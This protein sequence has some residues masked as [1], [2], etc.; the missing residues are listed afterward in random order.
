MYSMTGFGRCELELDGRKISLELKSVNHRYLDI[1]VRLPRSISYIEEV[2]KGA[3]KE[4]LNRG[5]VDVY[6]YYQNLRDD[7]KEVTVDEALLKSYHDVLQKIHAETGAANDISATSLARMPDVLSVQNV[8]EDEE[9]VIE[10]TKT[11]VHKALDGLIAMR[12]REGIKMAED[13]MEKA[14]AME[15]LV[16]VVSE[17]SPLVVTEYRDKLRARIADLMKD[18]TATLDENKLANEV[19]FFAD[20]CS[21][22]EEITRLNC[23]LE[24]LEQILKEEGAIGRRLD[25]LVQEMNREVNTI[26]SKAND[27]T[28]TNA[29]LKLKNEV[30]KIREQVQ[31][32]E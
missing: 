11:A 17:R 25:F 24:Q 21:I 12:E 16:A 10:L 8:D 1:N 14:A 28:I 15:K 19:T 23:H 29:G 20:R 2:V 5:H 26:C 32:L 30:E 6:I 3:L 18:S 9:A 7:S 27:I 22:A 13:I 4:R 31:N